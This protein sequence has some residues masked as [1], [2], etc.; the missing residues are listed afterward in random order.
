M[1]DW[2]HQIRGVEG[3]VN[4]IDAGETRIVETTPTGGGKTRIMQRLIEWA[5]AKH[6]KVV[7]Y[8]NRKMLVEQVSN[9]LNNAGIR[10]GIRAAGHEPELLREVQVSSIQ[11]EE[12]RVY[13]S[14]RWQLHAAN[15]V[16]IDECHNQ[17]GDTAAKVMRDHIAV[18]GVC[19]GFTATPLGL[20]GLWEH[21]VVAGTPSELR[22]CGALVP[23]MHFAPDEPDCSKIRRQKS[24]EFMYKD[25]KKVVM[26]STIFGR[27]LDHWKK[28]NPDARPA[29][30]FAPGVPESIWFAEQF[31]AAGIRAAHIDGENV[32]VD[33]ESFRSDRAA[34]DQVIAE[35]RTGQIP[36]V[37]N[38]FVLREGVDIPE[39]YHGILATPFGALTSYLQSVGRVLRAHPSMQHVILQDHGGNAVRHGSANADRNWQLGQTNYSVLSDR[40]ERLREK[41]EKE[42]IICPKCGAVRMTGAACVSCGHEHTTS[43]RMVVQ[44]DGTLKEVLGDVYVERKRV[45][46]NDTEYLWERMYWRAYH[47]KQGMTFRQ[48]EGLF[49]YENHY[50]PPRNLPLMPQNPN[51]WG[52]KAKDVPKSDLIQKARVCQ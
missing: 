44:T 16:L 35:V 20:G 21:L 40:E 2:P 29:I 38:R 47:S 33:G 14:N 41:K 49:F 27:V 32:V 15:L 7:L 23:A 13:K 8:T 48:A 18:G 42:P 46:R 11:T 9:Y 25:V 5:V 22:A 51:H 36:V 24:G 50:W 6:W 1:S 26:T 34:R 31:W 43:S 52:R 37:C 30:L 4:A 19:V 12:A 28:L 10:H 3:V 45:E 17:T 39:L